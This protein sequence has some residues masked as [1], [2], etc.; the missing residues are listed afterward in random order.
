MLASAQTGVRLQL[1]TSGGIGANPRLF[2]G[3]VTQSRPATM[4]ARDLGECR[5]DIGQ[6]DGRL[7]NSR[8]L[9]R[10]RRFDSDAEHSFM[11]SLKSVSGQQGG[12]TEWN[13]NGG[14]DK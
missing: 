10:S 9:C 11:T 13:Q 6:G 14:G 2:D 1:Q 8:C 3:W 4:P 7:A 5:V 12:E